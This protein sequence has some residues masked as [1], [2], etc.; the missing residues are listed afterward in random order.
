MRKSGIIIN[1]S[2]KQSMGVISIR[3]Y[4]AILIKVEIFFLIELSLPTIDVT[5]ANNVQNK[6]SYYDCSIKFDKSQTS[7]SISVPP[8]RSR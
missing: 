3:N 6:S 5:K 7:K 8:Q 2:E 4:T 1:K